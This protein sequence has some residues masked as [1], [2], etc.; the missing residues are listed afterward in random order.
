M[1]IRTYVHVY[2]IYVHCDVAMV[3]QV[4]EISDT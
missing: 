2:C 3:P 4:D 1:Y